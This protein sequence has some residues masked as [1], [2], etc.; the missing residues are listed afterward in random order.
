MAQFGFDEDAGRKLIERAKQLHPLLLRNAPLN[1]QR[2]E[3]TEEVIAALVE[4]EVWKMAVPRRWGGLCLSSNSMAC[5]A[6]ELAKGCPSTAWVVGVMNS[7][8]WL[9]SVTPDRIQEDLFSRSIPR[10]CSVGSPPGTAT[11]VS[12]GYSVSGRWGY[13][14]GSHHADWAYLM[15]TTLD[16]GAGTPGVVVLPMSEVTIDRTWLVSGMKGTGSDTIVM[17]NVFVPRHRCCSVAEVLNV[18]AP[19]MKKHFGEPSDYWSALPLLRSK[20]M[21]VLVGTVEG[22]LK[23]VADGVK[24]K[25]IVQTTY[26]H[27]SDSSVFQAGIGEAAGKIRTARLLLASTTHSVDAAALARRPL[28]PDERA[29]NRGE[30]AVAVELLSFASDKLMN[31]AGSSAF[32]D[33]NS[34]QRYWRDY[35]M[36]A[37]HAVH[38]Y[39]VGYEVYG[40]AL[41]GVEPNIVPP[42]FV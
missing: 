32:A 30:T 10:M 7:A 11:A 25:P 12:G 42:D 23:C 15:V 20:A 38:L 28:T 35:N 3:L 31:L 36:A 1:E 5:V 17:Q 41:L 19:G 16:G 40:R 18:S 14:S 8:V 22:L 6:A 26:A 9:A 2:G 13:A 21:G 27:K 39:E 34:A 37:R 24:N 33:S 4:V 29:A